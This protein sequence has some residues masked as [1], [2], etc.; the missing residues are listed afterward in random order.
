MKVYPNDD[1]HPA[2]PDPSDIQLYLRAKGWQQQEEASDSPV[3]PDVWIRPVEGETY[4]VIAPSRR[5]RDS[6]QRV[7]E[8]LRTLAIA[9]DRSEQDVL[10]E[11]TTA[12]FDIQYVHTRFPLPSGTAPL[13]DASRVLAAA[14]AMLSATT[15]SLEQPSLVLPLRRPTRTRS[16]MKRVLAGPSSAGSYVVSIMVPVP[17]MGTPRENPAPVDDR[18]EPFERA[19]TKHLHQALMVAQAAAA[20][21]YYSDVGLDAFLDREL[22]GMSANLCE[23]LAGLAGEASAG[24]DVHF[25]WSLYRPVRELEPS[26]SFDRY[27]IP[28]LREAARELRKRMPE[29]E[30]RIHGSVIRLHREMPFGGGRVTIEGLI[31]GELPEKLRRV[32]VDLGEPDYERAIRAHHSSSDVEAVGSIVQR[33]THTYLKDIRSFEVWPSKDSQWP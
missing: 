28:I 8:L 20:A 32:W 26:V 24:F 31:A 3:S 12:A 14:H 1:Q 5:A 30:A 11:L 15:A 6:A 18:H 22:S 2:S 4:E 19:A 17:P 10:R 16:L 23:A 7:A 21:A 33:G 25:S 29:Q 13:R 27:T 9:E